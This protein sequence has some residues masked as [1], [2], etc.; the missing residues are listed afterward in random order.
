VFTLHELIEKLIPLIPPPSLPSRPI[1]RHS[2]A[3]GQ[4]S[5]QGRADTA[6]VSRARS[7]ECRRG[8]HRQDRR[9]RVPRHRRNRDAKSQPPALGHPLETRV[10]DGRA[11]M[12]EVPR[13]HF[14]LRWT[15]YT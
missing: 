15:R 3:C 14:Q 5:R 1:P 7:G 6:Q 11:D 10:H 9:G 12:P 4:G 8:R 13:P 2:R